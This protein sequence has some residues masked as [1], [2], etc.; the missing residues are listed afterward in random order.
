MRCSAQSEGVKVS[1]LR[2][3]A[4][5]IGEELREIGGLFPGWEVFYSAWSDTWNAWRQGEEP[6]FG[7]P[8]SGRRFMVSAYDAVGLVASLE[9]QV[10]I[11]IG[12]DCPG[13]RVRQAASGG[14]YAIG[15]RSGNSHSYGAVVRLV[16]DP[17]VAGL[18]S[19]LRALAHRSVLPA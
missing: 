13:W 11:D 9:G 4:Q 10:R 18:H 7:R 19:T 5:T 12:M 2:I 1:Q 3:P 6:Y 17:A 14:W 15:S 8:A 16:H